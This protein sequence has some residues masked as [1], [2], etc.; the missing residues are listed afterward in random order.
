M[1][2]KNSRMSQHAK[3]SRATKQ[4]ASN[5]E[6]GNEMRGC[7]RNC[8]SS[9]TSSKTSNKT[10]NKTSAKSSTNAKNCK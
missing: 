6:A 7:A 5:V 3:K 10:S 9:S 4:S 2:G 1:L 8:K